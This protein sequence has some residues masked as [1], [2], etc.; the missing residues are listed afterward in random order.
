MRDGTNGFSM[1]FDFVYFEEF[2]DAE[3]AKREMQGRLI[4]G[5]SIFVGT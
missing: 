4:D 5:R 2:N 3:R 1:G